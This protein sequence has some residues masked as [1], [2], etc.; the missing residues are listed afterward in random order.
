MTKKLK[1]STQSTIS[2][3]TDTDLSLSESFSAFTVQIKELESLQIATRDLDSA[4]F[5]MHSDLTSS[6]VK[7]VRNKLVHY[8]AEGL[9]EGF[10]LALV[11]AVDDKTI[12]RVLKLVEETKK[13][14]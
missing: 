8:I 5:N 7:H 9:R 2:R 6:E 13:E 3:L 1:K 4:I 11:K 12:L 14:E 10:N